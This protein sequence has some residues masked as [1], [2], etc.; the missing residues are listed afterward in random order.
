MENPVHGLLLFQ[1]ADFFSNSFFSLVPYVKFVG[2]LFFKTCTTSQKC[3]GFW[4]CI[5]V[6]EILYI[7]GGWM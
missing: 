3:K 2:L 7:L 5:C 1:H 4:L 6:A